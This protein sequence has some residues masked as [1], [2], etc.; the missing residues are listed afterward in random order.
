[1]ARSV[2]FL[3]TIGTDKVLTDSLVDELARRGADPRDSR[4]HIALI[5]EWDTFYGRALPQTFI[6]SVRHK[7]DKRREIDWIHQFSYLRGI[8]GQLPVA[9]KSEATGS[10]S[11][12]N[13]KKDKETETIERPVGRSQFDY[14][15]RLAMRLERWDEKI[16]LEDEGSIEAIGVLGSDVY[17]KLLVLQAL[18]DRFPATIFFTTDLDARLLHR[19]DFKWSVGYPLYD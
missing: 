19:E 13:Q 14:L 16:R 17:D 12:D 1:M 9:S 4:N 2:T 3:R 7:S 18:R 10:V 11:L 8:D 15:R 5:S 6:S